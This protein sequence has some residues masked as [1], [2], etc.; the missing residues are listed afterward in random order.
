MSHPSTDPGAGALPSP[1]FVVLS[2]TDYAGK[3]VLLR[4]LAD[5]MPT[6][7]LVSVDQEFLAPEHGV[8]SRLKSELFGEVLPGVRKHYSVDFVASLLQ[9]AVV[10][11]RDQI[12]DCGARQPVIVDS[13]YYK[14]L[15]KC[16][17]IGA[18]DALV[19]WWRGLPQPREVLFL[20]VDPA[21]AW[22]RA[23]AGTRMN[24]L[25]FYGDH[26]DR[27]GFVTF[28]RD[29]R[30]ALLAELAHLPVRMLPEADVAGTVGRV[31]E[32]VARADT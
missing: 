4:G 25:E 22:A 1:P 21:T 16:R 10:Y 32:A 2:G 23:S 26:P 19:G 18:S 14:I 27:D 30:T 9:T 3:S 31:R 20:D 17:L 28:Q 7:R 24:W 11:L 13:Y 15:A 29:L 6:W 8:V 12:L 5:A